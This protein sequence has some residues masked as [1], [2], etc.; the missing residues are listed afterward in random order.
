MSDTYTAALLEA[1]FKA[2]LETSHGKRLFTYAYV[3]SENLN[4]AVLNFKDALHDLSIATVTGVQT[5]SLFGNVGVVG[6]AV[7]TGGSSAMN[8]TKTKSPLAKMLY[9]FGATFSGSAVLFGSQAALAKVCQLSGPA[10]LSE[11]FGASFLALGNKAHQAAL[12]AD[13]KLVV[14]L[15]PQQQYRD[16]DHL[17]KVRRFL[18]GRNNRSNIS[19]ITPGGGDIYFAE[20]ITMIP[21]EK[22]GRVVGVSLTMY[23]YYKLT[24]TGYRYSQKLVAKFYEN[25]NNKL[26]EKNKKLFHQRINFFIMSCYRIPKINRVL[27]V[28]NFALSC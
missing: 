13:A 23:G 26:Q 4:G 27:V 17:N 9:I 1:A 8:Y 21:F 12:K 18:S 25:R 11:S 16:P 7:Y 28:Y 3:V 20:I 5:A 10:M 6:L 15:T 22:I 14:P 24:I 2:G 19:F